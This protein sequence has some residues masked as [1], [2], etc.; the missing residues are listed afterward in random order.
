MKKLLPEAARLKAGGA[1]VTGTATA[2]T[3]F[4]S[5][6]PR[7]IHDR[8]GAAVRP[9]PV[10]ERLK[11]V[12]SARRSR[13]ARVGTAVVALSALMAPWL[14]AHAQAFCASDGE[15]QPVQ[16]LERFINA[17]CDTCW[18]DPATAA[19]K[20]G[21][22]TIDWV[23][24]GGKG[25]DA[26]LSA[27]ASRDGLSR[28][29]ALR[30]ALPSK[31]FDSIRPVRPL[32]STTLRVA[33]GIALS[34]YVGASIE[35]KP[36]RLTPMPQR[37]TA[38]LALIETIAMGTEGTPVERQLVRNVLQTQWLTDKS[39]EKTAPNRF[40]ESRVMSV[41][42]GVNPERLRV[43]GWVENGQGQVIAA[44]QSRCQPEG[45]AAPAR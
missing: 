36:A 1:A 13:A 9:T 19:A 27:V 3:R 34:G 21:Q 10:S 29:E 12:P 39:A 42:A 2:L 20:K 30:V 44:S 41:A 18:A 15:P 32:K 7:G 43:V 45:L 40:F 11:E 8:T 25:D 35:L 16:L 33:H 6:S 37:L 5:V 31:K 38:W 4:L 28:L 23:L 24:P 17:D 14:Q 22:L 26:A